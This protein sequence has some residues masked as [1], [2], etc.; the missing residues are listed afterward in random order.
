[1]RTLAFL[2]PLSARLAPSLA[3]PLWSADLLF[4]LRCPLFP[5]FPLF[6]ACTGSANGRLSRAIPARRILFRISMLLNGAKR[7]RREIVPRN[8]D[9]SQLQAEE[10]RM[11][12][13]TT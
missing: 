13:A 1:M 9:G 8:Y 5:L 7:R 12:L 4:S 3:P 10:S 11:W 2:V 6:C